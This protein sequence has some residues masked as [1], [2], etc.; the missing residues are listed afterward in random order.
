MFSDAKNTANEMDL[1]EYEDSYRKAKKALEKNSSTDYYMCYYEKLNYVVPIAFQCSL[2]LAVDFNG[3][4]INNIYNPS[5]EYRIQ[6]IH[7]SILPLKSETII[8]MFIEDGDK[9]YRQ[10]Y[11]QF[12]KLTLEDK[13]ATLTLIMFMYSEDMY[14][15]KSIENE[16]RE[17]KAL[18]EAGKTGQDIVSLTPFFDPMEILRESHSLDKRHDIPNLLSEKYKL[19]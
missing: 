13:L 6:N 15:S 19:A 7:I 11:K 3:N 16:V 17:S 8:V 4:I 18:C 5:P 2:A 12:N 10:F 1:K 14:F 9:R